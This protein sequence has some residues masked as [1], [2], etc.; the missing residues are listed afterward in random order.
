MTHPAPPTPEAA[1]APDTAPALDTAADAPESAATPPLPELPPVPPAPRGP[2]RGLRA[3]GRWT[4]AVLV[5]AV[6]GG[7]TAYAVTRPER[8]RL[9]GL[10][11][12]G[13]GR[14][15][16]P[17]LALPKLPAGR[18]R[19]L[20]ATKNPG[21]HHYVDVRS[22]LL[23]PPE[24]ARTDPAVP[25]PAGWLPT[26]DF[27]RLY[28]DM[29]AYLTGAQTDELRE[30]GLR[31]I[32]ARSWT[33]PDGTRTDVYLLQFTTAGFAGLYA[34]G[35]QAARIKAAAEADDDKAFAAGTSVPPAISVSGH[36]ERPPFGATAARYAWIYAGDTIALVVQARKGSVAEA[37][38]VQ[39]VR[40]QAQMLG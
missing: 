5:F 38:F 12:P 25:G 1:P 18:P 15:T 2:R 16:Y 24:T 21:G 31:H 6:L 33:M 13:D 26:A 40:L 39:T 7:A 14:W 35:T 10:A 23:T 36:A 17:P 30:Q 9:P 11:T 22:L 8:T 32:A 20:D 34:P 28:D 4:A 19:P 37:P 3:A 29:D 27:L